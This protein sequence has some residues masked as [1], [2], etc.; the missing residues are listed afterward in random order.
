MPI[1]LFK[2][3]QKYRQSRIIFAASSFAQDDYRKRPTIL[4]Q[5]LFAVSGNERFFHK[6]N[7]SVI[8]Q[9]MSNLLVAKMFGLPV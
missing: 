5:I 3:S 7:Y 6:V 1:L 9:H 4:V 2:A 8:L